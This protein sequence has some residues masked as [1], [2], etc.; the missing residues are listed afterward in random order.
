[1]LSF[2]G[3]GIKCLFIFERGEFFLFLNRKF[4]FGVEI[5]VEFFV[6]P[7]SSFDSLSGRKRL[8]GFLILDLV[9]FFFGWLLNLR[10]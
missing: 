7:V 1:M 8:F 6:F 4:L 2:Q 9:F 5:L 3:E 10:K